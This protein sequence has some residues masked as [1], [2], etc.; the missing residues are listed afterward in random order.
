MWGDACGQCIPSTLQP[1]E[2]AVTQYDRQSRR[3]TK[4]SRWRRRKEASVNRVGRWLVVEARDTKG[5]NE[6]R[7]DSFAFQ[8]HFPR[9]FGSFQLNSHL[10]LSRNCSIAAHHP[11]SP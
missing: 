1:H 10:P 3:Q 7:K 11:H 2:T 8:T 9:S 5:E 6:G 4:V